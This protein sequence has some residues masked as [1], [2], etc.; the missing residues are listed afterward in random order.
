MTQ[1]FI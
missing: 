1:D